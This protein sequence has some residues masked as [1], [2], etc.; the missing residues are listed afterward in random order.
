[1]LEQTRHVHQVLSPREQ[2]WVGDGFFVSTVFSPFVVD[3]QLI[4]PFLMLDYGAP[5][6]F[7]GSEKQRG[8]GEHP[9]RGFETVTFAYSGE[10]EH[11]DSNGG[12]GTIGPGDVQWMTAASGVVHEELFSKEFARTG[13]TLEMLQLWVNLPA[14]LK[15]SKPRYQTLPAAAFPT[16]SVGDAQS[17]LIAGRFEEHTGPANT[18]TPMR[19]LELDFPHGG[20]ARFESPKHHTALAVVLAGALHVTD[21]Q[22]AKRGDVVLFE[23]GGPRGLALSATQNSKVLMLEGE[24][25]G[26]PV[27]AH[28]PFVMNHPEEIREA[29]QDYQRGEMGHLP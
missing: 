17:R 6:D 27:S 20:E 28:G 21:R 9:H 13:G 11:R 22:Q 19:V 16:F 3:P 2:H 7:A 1:M 18:Y 10:I 29:I 26:E 24:P 4:S 5:K 14:R 25:L 23:R 15:M 12:G 8:V